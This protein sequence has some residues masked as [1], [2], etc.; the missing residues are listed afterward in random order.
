MPFSAA[1]EMETEMDTPALSQN[2][3]ATETRPNEPTRPTFRDHAL[4]FAEQGLSV[5]PLVPNKKIPLTS[6]GFKDASKLVD[7]VNKWWDEYPT[8]NIGIATGK[9]SGI[10]VID[11]DVKNGAK[12]RESLALLPGLPPTLTVSTPSGGWHL[13]YLAP[14]EGLRSRAGVLPGIDIRGDGGYVVAPGSVID[15]KTYEH[16]DAEAPVAA[17]PESILATL[18]RTNGA[19]PSPAPSVDGVIP[20]GMRDST[21]AS[22]AGSMRR[23]GM[24]YEEM[25]AALQVVNSRRC[26]PP[27][28]ADAVEKV[29]ASVARY[30][31]GATAPSSGSA[32]SEPSDSAPSVAG[33]VPLLFTDDALASEFTDEH[34]DDWRYVAVWGHWY[35]WDGARWRKE[36]TLKAFDL[37]RRICRRTAAA[38]KQPR[39]AS[40]ATVAAVERLAKADRGHSATIEQWDANHWLLNTPGGV[41]DLKTGELRPHD[42]ADYMTK[43]AAATPRGDAPIWRNFL[44]KVTDGDVEMQ[45]YLARV[46]G[47]SLTGNIAEHALFFFY[48]TGANGK[49]VFLNALANASGDYATNAPMDTFMESRNDR[50]PTDLAGLMGA[51]LVTAIEVESGRRW[52]EAKIKSLTGGDNITAR[53]MRQD[54]FTYAPQFKLLIAGNHRPSIQDVDDAIRRRLHL[55]PFTVTIPEKERDK[56]LAERLLAERDGIL[57]WALEGCLE[58]QRIGLKPP[59][60]VVDATAEY[61][62]SEDALGRWIEEACEKRPNATTPTSELFASWKMWSERRSEFTGT[63]R[64]FSED[65]AKRGFERWKSGSQKGFKGIALNDQET[66][67]EFM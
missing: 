5:I 20:D 7:A 57:R 65:F 30:P 38:S 8:A 48:G 19:R 27:L 42:R 50:H 18:S 62:E 35:H 2:N 24:G 36:T 34:V 52:A 26:K 15:G 55:I 13:Y 53:F 16:I 32:G 56:T 45:K 41:V 14:P 39:I 44:T 4:A 11:V 46:A 3:T 33:G 47:Y 29:A 60:S 25:V 22:L 54:F 31:T 9:E 64:K 21:L 58:W 28:P 40:A 66:Q 43:V 17:L 67:R 1:S 12:G 51:R 63:M 23:R 10:V 49:S 61:L 6:N 37:A 59:A